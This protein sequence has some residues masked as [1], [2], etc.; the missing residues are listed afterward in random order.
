LKN[1]LHLC[2]LHCILPPP[3]LGQGGLFCSAKG[4]APLTLCPR[5]ADGS[6]SAKQTPQPWQS[7]PD[8][9]EWLCAKASPWRCG[10]PRRALPSG[11]L[12]SSPSGGRSPG[13]WMQT[14]I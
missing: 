13:R 12:R 9:G 14:H 7:S 11:P 6:A 3:G 4:F 5:K 2:S 8:P 1:I 10:T